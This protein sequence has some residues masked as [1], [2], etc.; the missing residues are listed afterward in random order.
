MDLHDQ[1]KQLFPD[2]ILEEKDTN[3][4]KEVPQYG[5]QQTPIYCKYEK[6]RGKPVTLLE[7]YTGTEADFKRLTRNLKT[8]LGVGGSYKNDVIILQGDY[9]EAI[10]DF[11]RS[12]GFAVKRVGG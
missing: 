3:V 2:H 9:R 1:L 12:K 8:K 4:E 10:M 11:L 5:L 7:G 6:R